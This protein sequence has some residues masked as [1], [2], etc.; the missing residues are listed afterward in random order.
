M[1][2]S[3]H[4]DGGARGNPGPAGI[5]LI[6]TNPQNLPIYQQ[7]TF[8]GVKTNNEAE[9]H[10]L[11]ASLNWLLSSKK[12]YNISRVNYYSDSQLLIRQLLG[13]YKVKAANI[14]PL[15]QQAI[16][17]ISQ[18]NITI[19]FHHLLRDQNQLADQLANKAMDAA[20]K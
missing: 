3:I 17:L 20:A 13:I 18:L 7:S 5:G 15:Y 1:L 8:L 11:I 4:A 16:K 19:D 12:T 2:I 9:Y 6:V 14:I 10:A